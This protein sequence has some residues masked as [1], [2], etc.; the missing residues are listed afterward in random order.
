MNAV[1]DTA[2]SE[3]LN[4]SSPDNHAKNDGDVTKIL[5]SFKLFEGEIFSSDGCSRIRSS[6]LEQTQGQ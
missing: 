4:W 6:I 2:S 5:P 3:F 1:V